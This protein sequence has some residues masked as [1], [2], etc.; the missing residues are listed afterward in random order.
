M[1]MIEVYADVWCPFTHVGLRRLV[2]RRN[3]QD[4]DVGLRVHSWP[5]ELVNGKPM[6]AQFIG[7]EIDDLREQV[8]PDLFTG[9]RVA[10]FPTTTLPALALAEA[11]YGVDQ[12]RGEAMSLSIRAAL[13]EEGRDI[14][15]PQVL[16][17]LAASLDVPPASEADRAAVEASWVRGQQQGVV[18]SPH[19]FTPSGNYF[20]PALDIE[21]VDG[22]LVIKPDV[23]A[24]DAFV[25]ECFAPM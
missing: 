1:T 8:S 6:D 9:F 24:F 11:A 13:F 20:C 7:D 16:R 12:A 2:E 10:T 19:F 14:S 3:E 22:H 25:A 4:A 17:E 18:G 23:A 15:D 21:R 5:L